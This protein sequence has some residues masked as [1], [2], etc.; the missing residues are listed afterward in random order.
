MCEAGV[1]PRQ[2]LCRV[3]K[4]IIFSLLFADISTVS[5]QYCANAFK[6]DHTSSATHS[7]LLTVSVPSIPGSIRRVPSRDSQ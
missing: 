1:L 3:L 6:K 7:Q 4:S 5:F 2:A